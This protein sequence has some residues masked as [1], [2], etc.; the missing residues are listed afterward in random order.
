MTSL[1]RNQP[2]GRA[3]RQSRTEREIRPRLGA[4]SGLPR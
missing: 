3:R 2:T 4:L 1:G